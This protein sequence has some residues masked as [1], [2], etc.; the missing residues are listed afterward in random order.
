MVLRSGTSVTI[1]SCTKSSALERGLVIPDLPLSGTRSGWW[2][3]AKLRHEGRAHPF[4][5]F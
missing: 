1:Q 5:G 3:A 4:E 2:P